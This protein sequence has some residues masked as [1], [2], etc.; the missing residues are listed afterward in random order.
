MILVEYL[1]MMTHIDDQYEKQQLFLLNALQFNVHGLNILDELKI[2][3][4]KAKMTGG[5]IWI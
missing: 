3:C 1:V 2:E 4:R 5:L